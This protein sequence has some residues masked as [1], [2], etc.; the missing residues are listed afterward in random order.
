LNKSL[1]TCSILYALNLESN[2]EFKLAVT[3]KW[4]GHINGP[5]E[6]T[7]EDLNQMK[8]NFDAAA[9]DGVIDLDH[10]TVIKGTGEA[11]GW[12]KELEVR[13]NELWASKVEW[14][15]HGKELIKSGKYKYISPVLLPN[16]IE[17]TSGE[18][19]GWTIHSAALTNRPFLEELGE[20]IVNNKPNSNEGE[21][22]MTPEQKARLEALEAENKSLK[23]AQAA[24]REEAI[25]TS[26]DSA[27]AANKVNK[28]QRDSLIALGKANP[29]SLK[30]FLD[31]AKAIV[32]APGN[33]MFQNNN[34]NGGEEKIDVLK[35][36]GIE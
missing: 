3:G 27:I 1:I 9:V 36:G 34:Q 12:I 5:F 18:N 22:G 11:Y 26:V 21:Q 28:D 10:A 30:D 19:I 23:D 16:T 13:E 17:Q 29:E 25:T 32:V 15:E 7:L 33:D 14:L 35:L 20:I 24:A 31:K 8:K 2:N 4:Q 6:I